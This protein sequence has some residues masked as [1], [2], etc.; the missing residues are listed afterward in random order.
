MPAL[1]VAAENVTYKHFDCGTDASKATKDFLN[2][3]E[4]LH[5]DSVLGSAASRSNAKKIA[6]RATTTITVDTYFH[7]VTKASNQGTVTAKMVSDQLTALNAAYG[8]NNIKFNLKNTTYTVN[9]AWA[10]G[11]STND[12]AMKK[13][14]RQGTYAALNI[15]FQTDL[16]GN[17]LGQCTLPANV[18]SNP[19]PSVYVSD[20]CNVQAA[21]MPGGNIAGYNLGKTAVHEAGHWLGL[22][23]TFEG[24]S[25]SG[26][27]DFIADTPQES[28]STDGCPAKPAKDSCASVAGVDP[29]H[30]YMDYSTDAC[31]TNFTPGQGQRMQTMWSMYRSGK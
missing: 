7:V 14:L 15:Y 20:G 13:A 31:Y 26:N 1:M 12:A 18:G 11:N 19:S 2:T 30:N 8:A 6:S 9:D 24:Y 25:C 28:T 3:V 29:I 17:I 16:Y 22:L 21:T 27:G 23:H 5:S 10:M 4:A